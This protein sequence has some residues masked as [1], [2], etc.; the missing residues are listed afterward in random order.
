MKKMAAIALFALM[1]AV[2]LAQKDATGP[3]VTFYAEHEV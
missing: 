2:V 1:L 3:T